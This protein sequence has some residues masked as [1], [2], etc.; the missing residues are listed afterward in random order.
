MDKTQTIQKA[1]KERFDTVSKYHE[2]VGV[3][4]NGSQNYDLDVYTDSYK[5]DIDCRAIVLP[6]FDDIVLNHQPIS[7]T[8][9]ND[10]ESHIDIKDIRLMFDLFMKQNP[11]YIEILFT[12][13]YYLN[14]KYEK[15]MEIL[16]DQAERIGRYDEKKAAMAMAGTSKEKLAALEHPYPTRMDWINKFGYDPKQLHHILRINE[17]L[18]YYLTNQYSYRKCLHPEDADYLRAIKQGSLKKEDAEI[19]AKKT[20]EDTWNMAKTFEI[21]TMIIHN[22]DSKD[23]QKVVENLLNTCKTSIIK[24]YFKELL[25][26]DK[27]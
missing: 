17:L 6:T 12:D 15:D 1:L 13:Y 3:F 8:Y 5:S 18:K 20:D 16:M 26:E 7:S 11:A 19:L 9:I 25:L 21:P 4:L 27:V 2:T 10:D 24:K 23:N 22:I 14:P